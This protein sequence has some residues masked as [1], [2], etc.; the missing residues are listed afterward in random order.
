METYPVEKEFKNI[1]I[2]VSSAPVILHHGHEL[3]Y[4]TCGGNFESFV[5]ESC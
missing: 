3:L 5:L 2:N 1:G 4:V